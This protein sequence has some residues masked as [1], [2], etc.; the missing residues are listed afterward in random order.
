MDGNVTSELAPIGG[1]L[2]DE[3]NPVGFQP[4]AIVLP[5]MTAIK[6]VIGVTGVVGNSLVVIVFYKYKKLFQ[7]VKSVFIINQSFIDG[8]VSALLI[9][10]SFVRQYPAQ[11]QSG[12][13][14]DQYCNLWLSH[15]LLWG[16][17]TSSIY[18]LMAVSIERYVAIVHPVWHRWSYTKTKA[19]ASVVFIWLFGVVFIAS[20]VIPTTGV[21]NG[22]CIV[23][24]FRKSRDV[25]VIVAMLQIVVSLLLPLFVHSVCYF[26]ILAVLC[27]RV[28]EVGPS[29]VC[30]TSMITLAKSSDT[31]SGKSSMCTDNSQSTRAA[32]GKASQKKSPRMRTIA[33]KLTLVHQDTRRYLNNDKA[34]KNVVKTLAIV[35]VCYFMCW[36]PNK[37]Y[38]SLFVLGKL[39]SF[40]IIF[41]ATVV[42]VFVNCCI[43]PIIYIT[44][45]DVFKKGLTMLFR[46]SRNNV[47]FCDN[48]VNA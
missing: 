35:N 22:R 15:I 3:I 10:V 30:G 9:A 46:R 17:M 14:D 37:V 2:Q 33:T 16:L 48:L 11:Q 36:L 19:N 25:A 42:M 43:N 32:G 29:V 21:M 20:L 26:R 38:V 13:K 18:N 45:Y 34:K 24:Y 12:L 6:F 4:Y 8:A 5:L 23:S 1:N 44:T 40:G 28:P 41:Q 7:Q 47:C 31:F 27:K 39:S